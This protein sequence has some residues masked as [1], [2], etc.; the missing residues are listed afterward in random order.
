MA[1]TDTSTDP[2]LLKSLKHH[3]E[4]LKRTEH[5]LILYNQ[6]QRGLQKYGH[7]DGRI[8]LVFVTFL[9]GLLGKYATSPA[10]DPATRVKARL[11]QQRLMLYLPTS[12][13]NPP[14]HRPP[15]RRHA[16]CPRGRGK[17]GRVTT[18]RAGTDTGRRRATAPGRAGRGRAGR[19]T[20]HRPG[21]RTGTAAGAPSAPPV[22]AAKPEP[23]MES[24][25]PRPRNICVAH[26]AGEDRGAGRHVRG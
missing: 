18:H 22:V 2:S 21:T 26:S 17:A 14:A 8:E 16:L 4:G 7:E 9:H 11:I 15:P 12:S 24:S 10:C 25:R 23:V 13:T 6:I 5:G 3:L 19:A 20:T 1:G